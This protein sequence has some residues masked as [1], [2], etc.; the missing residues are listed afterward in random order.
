MQLSGIWIVNLDYIL[1]CR[2]WGW[3]AR[4]I[5]IH[6][7]RNFHSRNSLLKY[8]VTLK[9]QSPVENCQCLSLHWWGKYYALEGTSW[10][11]T[12]IPTP[13]LVYHE[14]EHS[15][16]PCIWPKAE[17]DLNANPEIEILRFQSLSSISTLLSTNHAISGCMRYE[18]PHGRCLR[19]ASCCEKSTSPFDQMQCWMYT[20][21]SSLR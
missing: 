1:G 4:G 3:R 21:V 5:F 6:V 13:L 10:Y 7:I 12:L 17:R 11:D 20:L 15:L 9:H 19:S 8:L 16:K 18:T 14:D 2:A